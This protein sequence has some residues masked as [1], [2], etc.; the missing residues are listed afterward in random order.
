MTPSLAVLPLPGPLV[1]V[2]DPSGA[3][4]ETRNL[5]GP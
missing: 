1:G 3:T 2:S 5:E 4:P